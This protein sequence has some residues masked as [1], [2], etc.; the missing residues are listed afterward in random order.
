[1]FFL[2]LSG[3][4]FHMKVVD[5]K[6][7]VERS[8]IPHQFRLTRRRKKLPT[9]REDIVWPFMCKIPA[10]K[11]FKGFQRCSQIWTKHGDME[12]TAYPPCYGWKNIFKGFWRCFNIIWSIK[13]LR[14]EWISVRIRICLVTVWDWWT[15]CSRRERRVVLCTS[16]TV[17][18][19]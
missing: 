13:A 10:L 19:R 9:M 4:Y 15:T 6:Q 5:K 14:Y 18:P 16:D 1:M 17:P 2:V 7:Q 12:N 8:L 3:T 11:T